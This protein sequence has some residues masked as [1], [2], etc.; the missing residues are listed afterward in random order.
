MSLENLV[1]LRSLK[2]LPL[3]PLFPNLPKFPKL[4]NTPYL[5]FNSLLIFYTNN[6]RARYFRNPLTVLSPPHPRRSCGTH[7]PPRRGLG[8]GSGLELPAEQAGVEVVIRG[9]RVSTLQMVLCKMNKKKSSSILLF[10]LFILDYFPNRTYSSRRSGRWG[11]RSGKPGCRS[12]SWGICV[13]S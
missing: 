12:R 11:N 2:I 13:C 8:G 7:P 3:F 9:N 4:P 10:F 6:G 5:P 1:S